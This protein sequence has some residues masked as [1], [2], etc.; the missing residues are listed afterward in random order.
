MMCQLGYHQE[1]LTARGSSD[2]S[3]FLF[4]FPLQVV[5]NTSK[6]ARLTWCYDGMSVGCFKS[7]DVPL[8]QV[9]TV[10]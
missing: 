5:N 1:P 8:D 7:Q 6:L 10:T 2:K 4:T 3:N 9:K